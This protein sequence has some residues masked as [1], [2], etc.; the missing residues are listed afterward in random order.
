MVRNLI[1]A[2]AVL[3]I[4]AGFFGWAIYATRG[5]GAW[6]N[7][8]GAIAL[9]IGV[10]AIGTGA[11]TALLMWLAF[12]SSRKGYDEPPKWTDEGD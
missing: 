9:M 4:A 6:S 8:S 2:F 1:L 10:G 3:V 11:L 7:G 12:Y 5:M